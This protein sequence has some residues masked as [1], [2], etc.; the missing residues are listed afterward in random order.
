MT[1]LK[2][3]SKK[4]K[5]NYSDFDTND[6][7][8]PNA[9][10]SYLQDIAGE[11]ANLLNVGYLDLLKSNYIWVVDKIRFEIIKDLKVNE[12]Y[13][14]QTWPL[15]ASLLQFQREF[16]ILDKNS[17]IL[18]KASSIWCVIDINSRKLVRANKIQFN[19]D[20][21]L[22]QKSF[23][24]GF[25]LFKPVNLSTYNKGILNKVSF[26][27]LDHN[28]HMNNVKYS[29]IAIDSIPNILNFKIKEFQINFQKECV[30]NDN[31]QTYYKNE[32]NVYNIVGI[33]NESITSFICSIKFDTINK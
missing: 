6:N 19:I 33:K 24:D 25:I 17:N 30:F 28:K 3:Y 15:K 13:T 16:N 29:I 9:I 26:S 32:N 4:I 1:D 12:E 20:E 11:H 2:L 14:L 7:I 18:L 10:L 23:D 22:T 27:Q 21:Y 31:L 5:F 8:F